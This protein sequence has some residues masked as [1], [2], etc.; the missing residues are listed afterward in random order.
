[1]DVITIYIDLD[2]D[3]SLEKLQEIKAVPKENI[4]KSLFLPTTKEEIYEFSYWAW[5]YSYSYR[6]NHPLYVEPDSP[7]VKLLKLQRNLLLRNTGSL[8]QAVAQMMFDDLKFQRK[9]ITKKDVF[10]AKV[11]AMETISKYL[12]VSSRLDREEQ[13][14]AGGPLKKATHKVPDIIENMR[15]KIVDFLLIMIADNGFDNTDLLLFNPPDEKMTV[16]TV[17]GIHMCYGISYS[18]MT[19][20][21]H[22]GHFNLM[23]AKLLRVGDF[24]TC[25]DDNTSGHDSRASIDKLER[26]QTA[27]GFVINEPKRYISKKGYLLAE[28][29]RLVKKDRN[30]KNYFRVI[31]NFKMRILVPKTENGNHW[32]TTPQVALIAL[33]NASRRLKQRVMSTIYK[34]FNKS[35]S[36]CLKAQLNIFAVPPNRPMFPYFLFGDKKNYLYESFQR[37]EFFKIKNIFT[38]KDE[39]QDLDRSIYRML[40]D[41]LHN[42]GNMWSVP[43]FGFPTKEVV[44]AEKKDWKKGDLLNALT[45]RMINNPYR[46]P[47]PSKRPAKLTAQECVYRFLKLKGKGHMNPDI[48]K[49]DTWDNEIIKTSLM[50]ILSDQR[51]FDENTTFANNIYDEK[52]IEVYLIDG[53]RESGILS[54]HF[55]DEH[56]MEVSTIGASQFYQQFSVKS[57]YVILAYSFAPTKTDRQ[58]I[59]SRT[60]S[61]FATWFV[62]PR[63]TM[64][65]FLL[66]CSRT[67]RNA[68][69]KHLITNLDLEVHNFYLKRVSEFFVPSRDECLNLGSMLIGQDLDF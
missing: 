13:H 38:P 35:Y 39:T 14:T 5:Y 59:C 24:A 21:N 56:E 53:S 29:L 15:L 50:G 1:M 66:K 58:Y 33:K 4:P 47:R 43:S 37:K 27:M 16:T 64:Q 12:S 57:V 41:G 20:I 25:G 62:P 32:V 23:E 55:G 68:K 7:T 30:G 3:M 48:H 60:G 10:Q 51:S 28:E 36:Y 45:A 52:D 31:S 42:E 17:K 34:Q 44:H 63:T 11:K 9:I 46:N 19:F 6:F 2:E 69:R 26:E 40:I 8:G 65:A 22:A 61:Y 67:F 49:M 54:S 18:A